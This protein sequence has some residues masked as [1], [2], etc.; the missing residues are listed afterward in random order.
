MI[1]T[2][3]LLGR[4]VDVGR[5]C[6]EFVTVDDIDAL[7]KVASSDL[8]EPSFDLGN[9]S[10]QR[11]GNCVPKDK[12]QDTAAE[13]E[14]YNGPLRRGVG[15]AAR[16]NA[17]HH[18]GFGFVDQLVRETLKTIGQRRGL[19]DL[20]FSC[21][22]ATAGTDQFHDLRHD[23]REPVVILP[24][25]VEQIDFILGHELQGSTSYPN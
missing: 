1:E 23:L 20:Q 15:L 14:A 19:G 9:R 24:K 22:H 5:Q 6:S 4:P 11:P 16:L 17:R 18:V 2:P 13:R 3:Q 7:G 25:P 21:F 10:N 8:T 12:C